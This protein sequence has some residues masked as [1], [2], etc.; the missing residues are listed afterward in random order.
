MEE[1][2]LLASANVLMASGTVMVLHLP[3]C[4]FT[5]YAVRDA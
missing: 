3:W 1:G 5:E 2:H 4:I